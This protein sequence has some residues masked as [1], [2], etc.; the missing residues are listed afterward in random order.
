[1]TEKLGPFVLKEVIGQGGMGKVYK[2]YD[3]INNRTVALKVIKDSLLKSPKA[4]KR[5]L[6]EAYIQAQLS[7]PSIIPIHGLEIHDE[8]IGYSM[9]FVEGHTLKNLMLTWRSGQDLMDLKERLRHFMMVIDAL[10]YTHEKGFIHRDIKADNIFIGIH[11]ETYLFDWG[12]ACKLSDQEASFED[13]D[14][15]QI[16]LTSPGKIPGTLTHLAPERAKGDKG[17]IRTDIFSL[18]VVLYQILTL[19]MPFLRKD[20]EHF[21]LVA[22]QES[23]ELP[24]NLN[25]K[26]DIDEALDLIVT[27]ALAN[28]PKERYK[29]LKTFKQDLQKVMNGLPVW[30]DP[31]NLDIHDSSLWL[32]QDLLPL[33][34]YLALSQK[35]LSWGLLSVPHMKLVDNY[36]LEIKA[37]LTS[38][39]KI[40]LNL[41]SDHKGFCFENCY[42]LH[43]TKDQLISLNRFDARLD[44]KKISLDTDDFLEISIEKLENSFFIYCRNECLFQFT[45]ILPHL[46]PHIG[47]VIEDTEFK[48]SR[49]K[50]YSASSSKQVSC[51]KIADTFLSHH[52]YDHAREHYQKIFTSFQEHLEGQEAL[53]KLGYSY[54]VQASK[55]KTGS[56]KL[57]SLATHVFESFKTHKAAPWEYWGKALCYK[58]LGQTDEMLK[59]FELG[60]RKY[61]KH[62]F[63]QELK[64]ELV[65][66]FSQKSINDKK[67]ALKLAL[68]A[69]RFLDDDTF[70][71]KYP[72]VIESLKEEL[73]S[74]FVLLTQEGLNLKQKLIFALSYALKQDGLLGEILSKSA[75]RDEKINALLMMQHLNSRKISTKA[76][77]NLSKDLL[78]PNFL[79][80]TLDLNFDPAFA[81]AKIACALFYK[82]NLNSISCQ[83]FESA[84][85]KGL[86]DLVTK[87]I[88]DQNFFYHT[89]DKQV[90]QALQQ[91]LSFGRDSLIQTL[92]SS[93][94][95]SSDQFIRTNFILGLLEGK[96]VDYFGYDKSCLE[97]AIKSLF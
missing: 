57:L 90:L 68:I 43:I 86:F 61:P 88:F 69:L 63:T 17:S 5:F 82:K 18:G 37:Q 35:A 1:M 91:G 6:K 28:D 21:K 30:K 38:D 74:C 16:E 62:A 78:I 9:P 12:L 81:K 75:S 51:L 87:K 96:I 80:E 97:F 72:A 41:S 46:G 4:K 3:L 39:F 10:E 2:A 48:F 55:C 59:C 53:F 29:D 13:D 8:G 84:F 49:L 42:I 7:H 64:E 26:E 15:L 79:D 76:F 40:Y 89:Q 77:K 27:R 31:K 50:L 14:P 95:Q 85:L 58:A 56:K 36:R 24:S 23:F 22:G 92:K 94:F 11:G 83:D 20:L 67:Q 32:F 52:L 19:K 25:Y 60:F 93:L 47:V 34:S 70:L 33:G 54:I 71:N 65:V 73:G 45:L 66:L 44:E